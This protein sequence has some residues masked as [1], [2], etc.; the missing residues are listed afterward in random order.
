MLA[1][2]QSEELQPPPQ[3]QPLHQR[4]KRVKL[5]LHERRRAAYSPGR[6]VPPPRP[7]SAAPRPCLRANGGHS[8]SSGSRREEDTREVLAWGADLMAKAVLPSV[9]L[10]TAPLS[11]LA[12]VATPRGGDAA[13]SEANPAPLDCGGW[14]GWGVGLLPCNPSGLTDRSDVPLLSQRDLLASGRGSA[15]RALLAPGALRE[16]LQV[17]AT[18]RFSF[19]NRIVGRQAHYW[20]EACVER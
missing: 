16:P 12:P 13:R 1:R 4:S 14:L 9:R 20:S 8:G 17:V 15:R 3:L 5:L 19:A 10:P 7:A 6:E 2:S 18:A 11:L